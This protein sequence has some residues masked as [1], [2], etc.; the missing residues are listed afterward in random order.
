MTRLEIG[1]IRGLVH[2]LEI[3]PVRTER[4]SNKQGEKAESK[5]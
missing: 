3:E 5:K 1:R 4:I 2:E